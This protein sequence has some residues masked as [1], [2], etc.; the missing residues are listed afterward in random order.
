[1]AARGRKPGFRMSNEHRVKIQ[2]SNILNALIEHAE[3]RRE[4]SST[5]VNAGLGLLDRVLPKLSAMTI[6]G[7]DTP[8]KTEETGVAAEKLA[9]FLAGIAERSG[10]TGDPAGE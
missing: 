7:G 1:M 4:M 8:I 6:E 2:N 3:G 10:N 5:Q 9:T